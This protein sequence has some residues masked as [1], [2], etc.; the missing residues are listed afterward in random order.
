VAGILWNRIT[1]KLPL[2]VDATFKYINGKTTATLT[3]AD[4]QI[5][6]PYNTYVYRGLPPTP[7]NNPGLDAINAALHPIQTKYIYFLTGTDGAMH[8]AVT[9]DE[10]KKNKER[11]LK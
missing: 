7:I 10:H 1:Q 6:S 2:Q 11:Y 4:L 3:L 8:Y 9:F 5:D